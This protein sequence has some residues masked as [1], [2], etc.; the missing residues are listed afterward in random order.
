[1]DYLKQNG[2]ILSLKN[3]SA[4]FFCLFIFSFCLH[5][6]K[7][8]RL[9]LLS[10]FWL[11]EGVLLVLSLLER[12]LL[13][14]QKNMLPWCIVAQGCW[15]LLA[16]KLLTRHCNGWH[17][18]ELMWN[19]SRELI[20]TLLQIVM[21]AKY[22]TPQLEK[23]SEQIAISYA[24]G[25]HWVQDGLRALFWTVTWTVG[26]GWWLMSIWGSK[27]EKIYSQLEILLMFQ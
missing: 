13:I 26:E 17:R 24:P 15:N 21:V 6:Q 22:I 5:L 20:W 3:V 7:M 16:Q 18:R 12:F 23:V 4:V 10:L 8:K 9:S 25:N 19:W 27:V 2:S 11:L 1:M 14:S